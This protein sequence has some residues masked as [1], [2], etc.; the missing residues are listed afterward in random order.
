MSGL[1]RV[2]SCPGPDALALGGNLDEYEQT[3][4]A[5]R[6]KPY[7]SSLVMRSWYSLSNGSNW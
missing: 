4:A 2:D 1:G 6:R 5:S 7:G 3:S